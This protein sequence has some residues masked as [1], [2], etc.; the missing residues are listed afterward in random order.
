[1]VHDVTEEGLRWTFIATEKYRQLP[2][3]RVP[4]CCGGV[5]TAEEYVATHAERHLEKF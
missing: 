1:M 5:H 4:P 2:S 3:D